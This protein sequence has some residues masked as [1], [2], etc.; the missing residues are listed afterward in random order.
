MEA[1]FGLVG[2]G[3]SL[4]AIG[5]ALEKDHRVI[6]FLLARRGGI[7]VTV[8]RLSGRTLT[9]AER[10]DISRGIASGWSIQA[11]AKGLQRAFST[12]SRANEADRQAWESALRPKP[13]RLA[14][15]RKLQEIVASRLVQDRSPKQISNR[16][17][18]FGQGKWGPFLRPRK[19]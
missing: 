7:A 12:V 3:Q 8:R 15:H 17:R 10:K 9:L 11:I 16:T 5:R 13:C 19:E 14:T 18:T 1:V 4:H 2:A 6:R